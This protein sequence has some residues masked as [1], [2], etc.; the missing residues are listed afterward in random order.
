[1]LAGGEDW[2]EH[3]IR[4]MAYYPQLYIDLA[5]LLWVEP[6]TQRYVK[7][8]LKNLKEAGYLNRVM[9]G[10]DQMV[11]PYAIGKSIGFLNSLTFLTKKDK[12]D[13]LYNNAACFLGLKK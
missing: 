6:N 13:I 10:S 2:P 5:V 1:M 11:W 8:L 9:F 7:Q 12:E 4:M 3:A